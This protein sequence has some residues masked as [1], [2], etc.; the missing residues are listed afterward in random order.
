MLRSL[1]IGF[2]VLWAACCVAEEVDVKYHKRV[3]LGSSFICSDI[4]R[5]SFI[6]RLC[7]DKAKSYLIM[8]LNQTYY[9]WCAVPQESVDALM[10]ADS[11]GRYFNANVKGKFDCR[12]N[13]PP[14]Y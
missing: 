11:M 10:S 7:Y 1:I 13:S 14:T 3:D 6:K 9:H 4:D 5:S 2:L 8:R 12:L